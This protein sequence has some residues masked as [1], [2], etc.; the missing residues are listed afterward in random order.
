MQ[1]ITVPNPQE[2][3]EFL[4]EFFKLYWGDVKT[5][6]PEDKIL[7][8]IIRTYPGAVEYILR[9][10]WVHAHIIC[11]GDYKNNP[12]LLYNTMMPLIM[13]KIKTIKPLTPDVLNEIMVIALSSAHFREV[14]L[15]S[16]ERA[17]IKA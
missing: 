14:L 8:S 13:E 16:C 17:Y 7:L 10:A 5:P 15:R 2:I 11:I 3:Q 12:S 6:L 9:R 4:A 1:Q